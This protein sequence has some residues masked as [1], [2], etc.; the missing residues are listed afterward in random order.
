MKSFAIFFSIEVGIVKLP[1][2]ESIGFI[3]VVD[4]SEFAIALESVTLYNWVYDVP[5]VVIV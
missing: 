1:D 2:V 3:L 5:E 4:T